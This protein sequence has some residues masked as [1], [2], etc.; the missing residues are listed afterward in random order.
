M[1]RAS[2]GSTATLNAEAIAKAIN[3]ATNDINS[4]A[5]ATFNAGVV[6]ITYNESTYTVAPLVYN[7]NSSAYIAVTVLTGDDTPALFKAAAAVSTAASFE[8][9]YAWV[10]ETCYA[11][12]GTTEATD[13]GIYTVSGNYGLKLIAES[14]GKLMIVSADGVLNKADV[15]YGTSLGGTFTGVNASFGIGTYDELV[16]L[17]SA[18]MYWRGAMDTASLP[19]KSPKTKYTRTGKIFDMYTL[20][21][22]TNY[23][24]PFGMTNKV[25]NNVSTLRIRDRLFVAGN[26]LIDPAM[27]DSSRVRELETLVPLLGEAQLVVMPQGKEL[28]MD[29]TNVSRL[30]STWLYLESSSGSRAA[31]E[32][33]GDRFPDIDIHGCRFDGVVHVNQAMM[34]L[35]SNTIV[36][37]SGLVKPDQLPRCLDSWQKI[38]VP[39]LR[40][41]LLAITPDTV[42]ADHVDTDVKM[43]IRNRGF[44]VIS[45]SLRHAPELRTGIHSITLDLDRQA[46]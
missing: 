21:I 9:D 22:V 4:I 26:T 34:V 2:A 15:T 16:N 7:D 20:Q 19:N 24:A 17:E 45:H 40:G 12:G 44:N 5:F 28:T 3:L 6:T 32:W 35:G 41:E 29:A 18:N 37:D 43:E 33:L 10:G 14:F 27:K 30:G 31:G 8:L 36:L 13:T 38:W 25:G 46:T 42:I 1:H 11:K 39:N 23:A